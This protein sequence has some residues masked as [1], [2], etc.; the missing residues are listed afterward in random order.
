MKTNWV[1]PAQWGT[2]VKS[3]SYEGVPLEVLNPRFTSDGGHLNALGE[4]IVAARLI[5]LIAALP[6]Q[7][8]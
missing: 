8:R 4:K 1:S 2:A 6:E 5:R 7:V 3:Q